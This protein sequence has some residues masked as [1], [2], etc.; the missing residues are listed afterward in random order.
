MWLMMKFNWMFIV[1]P[2]LYG[3][4]F[5]KANDKHYES[6]YEHARKMDNVNYIGY[7]PN[8]EIIDAMQ[9]SH[10]F[11][12]PCIWEETSCNFSNRSDGSGEHSS[13]HKLWS[14]P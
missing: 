13:G 4:D 7:K 10:V 11:A 2:Q 3:D 14:A 12:Y 9:A 6:L 1:L 5:K 8:L